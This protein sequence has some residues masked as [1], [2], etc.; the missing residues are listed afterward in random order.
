MLGRNCKLNKLLFFFLMKNKLLLRFQPIQGTTVFEALGGP[1]C[2]AKCKQYCNTHSYRIIDLSF[3][4]KE[5]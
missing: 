2:R 4:V 5:S 1:E 3:F